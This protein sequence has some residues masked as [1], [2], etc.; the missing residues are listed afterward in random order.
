M[1]AFL[2]L[3]TLS[4]TLSSC[5]IGEELP[6]DQQTWEYGNPSDVNLSNEDFLSLNSTIA[7]GTYDR[8][9]GMIIVK[10]DRLIFENYYSDTLERHS[11][12]PL[13]PSSIIFTI[14][15]IGIAEDQQLLSLSDPIHNYLPAYSSIFS[16]DVLKQQITIEH[17]LTH[18][19][20]FAWNETV[21]ATIGN[22]ENNLNQMTASDDW[23]EFILNRPV[24]AQ[25]GL[26]YNFNSGGGI[27]LTKIIENAAEQAFS[28][29]LNSNLF[30]L[31]DVT[32]FRIDQ[33]PS[34]N[35]DGGLGISVSLIDWTKFT[36][37]L[38]KEGRK[39]GRKIIDPNFIK[40]STSIQRQVCSNF[41]L[42]YGWRLFGDTFESSFMFGKDN[43]YY[44]RGEMGQD[45]YVIKEEDMIIS[46]YATNF[47]D[48]VDASFDLFIDI[49]LLIPE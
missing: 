24:E 2:H 31:I 32:S 11:I 47:F 5:F 44:I 49:T 17:L 36:Y 19:S 13:G 10:D 40:E 38:L 16:E 39:N 23:I 27:I 18:S 45:Q 33:D 43:A 30:E 20:G 34:G 21:V 3:L 22:A 28:D 26:R 29:F 8:I 14:A 6:P 7:L 41:N 25:P 46:L 37:L 48:R 42:G 35:L 15:G 4:L 1:K 12:L 9:G